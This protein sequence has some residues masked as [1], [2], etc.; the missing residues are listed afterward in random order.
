MIELQRA[1][2]DSMITLDGT[3]TD[4]DKPFDIADAHDAAVW[5][6]AERG[7]RAHHDDLAVALN[8]ESAHPAVRARIERIERAARCELPDAAP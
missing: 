1:M 2:K 5:R 6:P 3:H 7:E 4:L 8:G